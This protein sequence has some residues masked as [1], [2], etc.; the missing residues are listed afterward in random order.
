MSK[1][2]K[3]KKKVRKNQLVNLGRS[4]NLVI[5]RGK[6]N[7]QKITLGVISEINQINIK[8]NINKNIIED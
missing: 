2:W 8:K 1:Q 6:I 7:I 5:N 3:M 4:V